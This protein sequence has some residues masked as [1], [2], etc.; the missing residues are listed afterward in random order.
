MG[1]MLKNLV[2]PYIQSTTVLCDNYSIVVR[3]A[4]ISLH[5]NNNP[6]KC[7]GVGAGGATASLLL[8]Y[9]EQSPPLFINACI[10]THAIN[11]IAGTLDLFLTV[12]GRICPPHF[13]YCCYPS[14]VIAPLGGLGHIQV[15]RGGQVSAL[16]D[17]TKVAQGD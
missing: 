15:Y 3:T 4:I 17:Q 7:R 5:I 14:E 6:T 9:W 16:G 11:P 13:L 12:H 1:M 10:F 8:L 2:H